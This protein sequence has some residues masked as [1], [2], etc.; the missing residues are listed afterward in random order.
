MDG[1]LAVGPEVGEA[2][3]GGVRSG[4]RPEVPQG[5]QGL[6]LIAVVGIQKGDIVPL[7][8]LETQIPG[9]ADALVFLPV[10]DPDPGV[11]G[12]ELVAKG[13]GTVGAAVVH[14]EELPVGKGLAGHAVQTAVQELLRLVDGDDDRDTGHD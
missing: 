8:L 2:A 11:L 10:E 4:L 5:F 6:E 1:V 14:Q 13:R 3:G 12:G 7:G 9:G